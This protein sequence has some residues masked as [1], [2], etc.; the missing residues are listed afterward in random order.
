MILVYDASIYIALKKGMSLYQKEKINLF[1]I[2]TA[3]YLFH[4][5]KLKKNKQVML[6]FDVICPICGEVHSFK[7]CVH[8]ILKCHMIIGGCNKTGYAIFFMGQESKVNNMIN[9]Q[10]EAKQKVYAMI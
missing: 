1:N 8:E 5:I 10:K 3:A 9:K 6:S 2:S 7:Y 4:S